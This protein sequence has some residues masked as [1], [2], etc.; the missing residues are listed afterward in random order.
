[1]LEGVILVV[2]GLLGIGGA[3][4]VGLIIAGVA[5]IVG[6]AFAYSYVVWRDDPERRTT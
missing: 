2:A 4:Q 5:V 3:V 6:L 1:V